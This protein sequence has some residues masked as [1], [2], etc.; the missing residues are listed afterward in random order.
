MLLTAQG[1]VE[2]Q[3]APTAPWQV[4]RPG[5]RLRV[6]D[7]LRTHKHSRAAVRLSDSSVLRVNEL[8]VLEIQAPLRQK[9][10][11]L[12]DLKSGSAYFF[13]R[14]K[15]E[16]IQFRT[17]V[18]VGAIRGTE[19]HVQVGELGT[20]EV[21][22]LDGEIELENARGGLILKSGEVARTAA[23]QAPVK[24]A[25]IGAMGV[26]QWCLYYPAVL[27]VAE[28]PLSPDA[29]AVLTESLKAYR[30]GDLLTAL[31]NYPA[32]RQPSS[33]AERLYLAA[34]LLAVGQVAQAEQTLQ[35]FSEAPATDRDQGR[36][37][38]LAAA[39]RTLIAAVRFEPLAPKDSA[40]KEPE[41]ATALLAVSYYEQARGDLAGALQTAR[42][43]TQVAPSFGFA[44]ARVAELEFGFGRPGATEAALAQALRF[45]PRHAHA[46]AIRGFLLTARHRFDAALES[47]NRAI[48]IDGALGNA[49]L[50]RGLCKIY[51]ALKVPLHDPRG[52]EDGRQDLQVAAALEPNRALL[53]SYLGKAFAQLGRLVLAEKELRLAKQ[54]D[55]DDPTAW[56]YSALLNQERQRI[57]EAIRDLERSTALNDHRRLYRSRL[58]LDQDRAVRNAN[59]A[60]AYRDAGLFEVS[61]R[62]AMRAVDAD[63][64]NSSAHLFLAES[65]D[66]LGDPRR[67]N[68]RYET[69]RTSELLLANLLAPA[70]SGNLSQHVSQQEYS[71]LFAGSTLGLSSANEYFSG[72]DWVHYGTQFGTVDNTSYAVDSFYRR[73]NGQRPNSAL[74]QLNLSVQVKQQF[75]PRDSVYLH[76]ESYDAQSGDVSQYYLPGQASPTLHVRERQEP[77]VFLGYHHEW[78]PGTHTLLLAGRLDDTLVLEEPA[79]APLFLRMLNGAVTRVAPAPLHQWRYRSQLEAYTTEL[80]HL[81]QA[82]AY[83]VVLGGRYQAGGNDTHSTLADVFAQPVAEQR[84]DTELERTSFY[85]YAQWRVFEPLRLTA[86]MS[87]DRLNFPRNIDIAPLTAAQERKEQFSPKAG[88]V[89]TPWTG[90]A[91]RASYTRSLGGLF[92]D[93]S[94][95]LEPT[96]VGGFN[97]AFRSLIPESA[98]GLVPGTEFETAAV[99]FDQKFAT[100]TYFGIEVDRLASEADRTLGV[101]TNSGFFPVPDSPSSTRQHLDFEERTLLV[102]VHQLVGRDF[103]F[104]A[105]YRLSDADLD[106]RFAEISPTAAGVAELNQQV[107]ATLHQLTFQA[108]FNHPSGWFAQFQSVWSRQ[109]NRGYAP[110]RPGDDFWQHHVFAGYRFSRRRAE[111]RLGLLNLTDQDYRLNP[112]NLYAEL[113][114]ERTLAVSFK[115]N[116]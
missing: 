53:R 59:L 36:L 48:E 34:L 9:Q 105:R 115:I 81:W 27:H 19:F 38:A 102:T 55:P 113:P 30:E 25:L 15:P 91:V 21:A 104:G 24:T 33:G 35:R 47:F 45:S 51:S 52:W 40:R 80:Q 43:A 92:F 116:L 77:N 74:E 17:P 90:G 16:E 85:G 64:A 72:G 31:A 71:R 68:L 99:G 12:I 73:E 70:G 26:I 94:F 82:E 75:G 96:Q 41:S 109:S 79:A 14:E 10:L 6:G 44:W 84:L 49:W 89:L 87:Y 106:G 66:Y 39:L 22:L 78:N 4:A 50:G 62:E 3:A 98:V 93:Q 67:F 8:T 61:L 63:Q 110:P 97:Q 56:L 20:T 103:A 95:R 32:E 23:G 46:L 76:V 2:L 86:G 65:Y 18:L 60:L 111:L 58:L 5:H 112:L 101:L 42:Q 13:S 28:L 54:L 29:T 57:N 100:D 11:P 88:L 37:A 7:R 114:R 69:A 1:Q 107:E 108:V 83:S